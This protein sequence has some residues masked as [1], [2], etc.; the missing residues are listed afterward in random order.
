MFKLKFLFALD[1]FP[2]HTK[3]LLKSTIQQTLLRIEII[4]DYAAI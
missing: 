1:I 3:H 2:S 4:I